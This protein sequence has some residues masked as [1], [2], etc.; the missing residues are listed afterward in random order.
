M[1]KML[2]KIEEKKKKK[3]IFMKIAQALKGLGGGLIKQN[4][5]IDPNPQLFVWRHIYRAGLNQKYP[6]C[7]KFDPPY[8]GSEVSIE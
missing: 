6:S 2:P 5:P 4:R 3:R 8:M 7:S 1:R